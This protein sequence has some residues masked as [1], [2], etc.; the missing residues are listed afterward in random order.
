LTVLVKDA[1]GGASWDPGEQELALLRFTVNPDVTD[2]YL[3][4]NIIDVQAQ[5]DG[6]SA[7]FDPLHAV[8]FVT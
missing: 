5:R 7:P 3:K 2:P 4:L 8:L 1:S 6:A